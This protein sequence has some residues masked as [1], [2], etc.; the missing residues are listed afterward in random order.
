M[1]KLFV[2]G[3]LKDRFEGEPAT[4]K[5]KCYHLGAYPAITEVDTPDSWTVHGKVITVN[6]DILSELD[7][8]E[9]YPYL[10]HRQIHKVNGEYVQLYVYTQP[11]EIEHKPACVNF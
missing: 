8:I 9:G 3:I 10:Y 7:M 11:E 6:A 4:I 2:Y 1:I 5:A